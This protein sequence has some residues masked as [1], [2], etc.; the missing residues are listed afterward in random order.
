MN[1]PGTG[2]AASLLHGK[3]IAIA[4]AGPCGLTLARLLQQKGGDVRVFELES[5]N[6]A[7]N[8][9]GSLDLHEDSGQLALRKAGLHEKFRSASRPE[10]QAI[11]VV[12][13]HGK[14]CVDLQPKD[15]AETRPEIDRGVLRGLLIDSLATETIQWGQPIVSVE[16]SGQGRL[17]L[18]FAARQ[19][20]DADLVFGCDGAWSKVRPFLSTT[21][22]YYCGITVVETWI[23]AVDTRHP[24]LARLVGPGIFCALSDDKALI[25]Q[26]NGDG[27]IRVYVTFRVSE[28]WTQR[29]GL[30]F[31]QIEST[32]EGLGKIF[33]GWAPQLCELLSASDVFIP[34]PL[35]THPP[36]QAAW[37]ARTDVTL[38]GDA[39]HVM[40]FFT[41]KGVNL[42]MLDA[43]ELADNLTSGEFSTVAD[44][45]RAY[46][47]TMF[48]RMAAAICEN[49]ADQDVFISSVAPA[50]VQDLFRRR[51]EGGIERQEHKSRA[52]S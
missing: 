1:E 38:L 27:K 45:V 31:K 11:R 48:D 19:H 44:A 49:L 24:R 15:E 47:A 3:R 25:A 33:A 29:S 4:G 7:R 51:I 26:R 9:G 10:G 6:A 18:A 28:D 41:G 23:S 16:R 22:P 46:E 21:K 14:L 30:D 50:G 35:Y 13:K 40:P 42:A 34:R 52:G 20:M 5:S 37:Y 17:R 8:Q 32:R 2:G 39:A 12:D 43:L 36:R